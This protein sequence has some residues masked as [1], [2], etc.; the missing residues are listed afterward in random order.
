[1]PGDARAIRLSGG[2][3]YQQDH[4]PPLFTLTAVA[5]YVVFFASQWRRAD[6]SAF[7]AYPWRVADGEFWRLITCTFLHGGLMHIAFNLAFFVR[8]APVIDNWLGPWFAL[9][10]YAFVAVSSSAA[11]LLVSE[12][13]MVGASGVVYGLFGFLWVMS[14]RRDDAAEVAGPHVAQTMFGWLGV[15]FVLN[16]FGGNIGNTAHLWGLLLGW[17]VGQC[18]V[19]RRRRRGLMI[20]AT[21]LAWALPIPF[22]YRPVWERTLA[23]VPVLRHYYPNE[24]P[25]PARQLYE[26]PDSQPEVGIIPA[27]RR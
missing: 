8:L 13:G 2:M 1:L 11:Q 22:T 27:R 5:A 7:Y 25:E 14:R 20:A 12:S 4:G 10:F 24:V 16:L 23:H 17:L 18:F 3:R 6:L 19:S 9:G 15:C 26:D 21:V